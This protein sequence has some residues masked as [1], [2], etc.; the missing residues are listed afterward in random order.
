MNQSK[1]G[2][3]FVQVNIELPQSL[4]ENQ[5]KIIKELSETGI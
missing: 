1:S 3:L 5:K 2:D 4:T